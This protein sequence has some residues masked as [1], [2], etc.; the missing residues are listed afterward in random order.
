MGF[1]RI[2]VAGIEVLQGAVVVAT[3]ATVATDGDN[4]DEA[5]DTERDQ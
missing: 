4:D 1:S 5:H 3:V 2:R